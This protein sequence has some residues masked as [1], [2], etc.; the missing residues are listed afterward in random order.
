MNRDLIYKYIH[1]VS[2]HSIDAFSNHLSQFWYYFLASFPL[3]GAGRTTSFLPRFVT[4]TTSLGVIVALVTPDFFCMDTSPRTNVS[5]GSISFSFRISS[6]CLRVL[7]SMAVRG[8]SWC[9]QTRAKTRCLYCSG[10]MLGTHQGAS[11]RCTWGV[12][13]EKTID[14][15]DVDGTFV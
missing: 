8:I 13:D 4:N 3:Q 1:L 12:G 11:K 6:C 9:P 10:A 15:H 7:Y 5:I 2:N 14:D